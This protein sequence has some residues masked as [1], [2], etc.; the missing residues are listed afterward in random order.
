MSRQAVVH[1]VMDGERW[2]LIAWRYYR[3]VRQTPRLVEANP[4]A[5]RAGLLPAG[6][7]IA[8]PLITRPATVTH[9]GLPP[10]KR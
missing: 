7:K 8:V 4:H 10:W 5:P 2:D 3:D 9:E 6:L 1:T